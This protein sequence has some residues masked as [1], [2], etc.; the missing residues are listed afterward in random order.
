MPLFKQ[1]SILLLMVMVLTSCATISPNFE[2]PQVSITSFTIA[3]ET[4]GIPVFDIGLR[5][6]NPNN[7]ALPLVGM[8]YSVEVEGNRILTGAE[9]NL[10]KIGA[11]ETADFTIQA[12]PDLLGGARLL[13][14]LIT[15]KSDSLNYLF[16]A[17]LDV[18]SLM[19]YI[20]ID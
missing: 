6:I 1:Y 9:P 17:K 19:P 7:S 12:T 8:S 2:K 16:N 13:Q 20:T 3:P 4:K 14:Y 18:G 11:Y 10:P 15:N 5:V